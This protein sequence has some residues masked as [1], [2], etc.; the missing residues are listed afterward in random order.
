[1]TSSRM[2]CHV[3][4]LLAMTKAAAIASPLSSLRA[5]RGN[6]CPSRH[7]ERSAAIHAPLVIASAARQSMYAGY[8]RPGYKSCQ[9]G[10]IAS[11]KA[12]FFAREPALNCFSRLMAS[13]M[14]P[15]N[16]K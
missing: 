13:Y 9:W 10:F 3:A 8:S 16:S 12:I 15:C 6:P 14:V 11:I 2:D 1:M 4:T 7:C 5:Q